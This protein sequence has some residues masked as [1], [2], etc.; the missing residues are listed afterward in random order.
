M[1][2]TLAQQKDA[3]RRITDQIIAESD[4][5]DITWRHLS[6]QSD[7]ELLP[8]LGEEFG[9]VSR[10]MLPGNKPGDLAKELNQLGRVVK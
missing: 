2:R 3:Q 4:R 9:E 1:Y 7:Y 5:Q 10:A 6:P 8:V